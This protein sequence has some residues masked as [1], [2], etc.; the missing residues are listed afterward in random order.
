[1]FRKML[2]ALAVGALAGVAGTGT[3]SALTL[4]T[5]IDL[6]YSYTQDNVGDDV[7]ASTQY[8]QKYEIKYETA[9]TTAYDFVG[10]VRVTLQ[11]A[12]YTDQ[13]N[14][15]QVSPTLE[16]ETKSSLVAAK[17]AYEAQIGSTDFYQ[18]TGDAT[19]YSSSLSFDLELTPEYWPEVKLKYQKKRDFQD[20]T[21]EG[22]TNSYEFSTR[23][24]IYGLRLEYNLRREDIEALLPTKTAS[25]ETKWSGKATFKE[26][27]WG[28]TEFELAYEIN[29]A[30]KSTDT[31]N[32]FSGESES[33]TQT[34][35]TRL[36][37][38]LVV[39]PRLTLGLLWEYQYDQDLLALD[40]DYKLKNK[41]ALDVRW[42]T[43][44][45]LKVTGE[46][47]RETDISTIVDE[48]NVESVTDTLK[49]GFVMTSISWLQI[50]G[51]AELKRDDK[52]AKN[53]GAS[54]DQT[55]EDKYEIILK[56]RI[57]EFWELTVDG[58]A[59]S[60][61]NDGLLT[62]RETKVKSDLKLKVGDLTVTPSYE[63]T[64]LNEWDREFDFPI[65]QQQIQE[66]KIK[67]E[68]QM[69][70]VD[71]FKAT[72]THEYGLKIDDTLDEVLNFERQLQ[73]SEDTRL[74]VVLAEIVRD[75]RLEGEI[76][77]SA[78]DTE[79]DGDPQLVELSYSLK[80]D[81]KLERFSLLTTI[82]Y[83]DKGDTFDDV[84]FNTKAS[85]KISTLE[86]TGEYQFDKTLV[87][88]TEPKD[89]TRKLNLKLNYKF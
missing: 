27:L 32:V 48:D 31:R 7:N 72:F 45:W 18:E 9:L 26:A 22:T 60:T 34:L 16:L 39:G 30:Y 57:G 51:K 28:G 33:Y 35:K 36:K 69:Q 71:L 12:W 41:Y 87:D 11:D 86:F 37:N 40:F 80:L 25:A 61:R 50:S 3:A 59:T 14:T 64:R 13:A 58:T 79:D 81:W 68:Y 76:D 55:D 21:T 29:E 73:F 52:I 20:Y 77:R 24:D 43:F 47:R 70:L 4:K 63:A 6:D 38:S 89:E 66:A 10:A 67:F 42:D 5:T 54:V 8:T 62:K 78:S 19:T 17:I 88:S 44:D 15:S 65:S 49:A 74:S 1:M 85:Y 83:N 82:K 53:S 56:N 84:S 2:A 23:K 75:V 46:A